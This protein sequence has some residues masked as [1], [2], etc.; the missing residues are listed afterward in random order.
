[1]STGALDRIGQEHTVYI[2]VPYI[3][4]SDE[5]FW[6]RWYHEGMENRY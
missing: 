3:E 1:M 2:H 4:N 6:L 5:A